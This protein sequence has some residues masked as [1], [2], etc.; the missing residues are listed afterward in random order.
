[1]ASVISNYALVSLSELLGALQQPGDTLGPQDNRRERIINQVSEEIESYLGRQLVTRGNLTEFHTLPS[2]RQEIRL[3]EFPATS[4]VSVHE[5]S[6]WEGKAYADWYGASTLL[7]A[8][9]HYLILT[10]AR[11]PGAGTRLYR[12]NSTWPMGRR[13]IKVVYTA[14]YANTAA[15]PAVIKGV[16]LEVCARIWRDQAQSQHGITSV[17]DATGTITRMLP[18]LLLEE[19]RRKL[20][21]YSN[22]EVAPTW[23]R[24]A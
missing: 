1:M 15:V 7:T 22:L 12:L 21:A 4:V 3:G 19:D 10:N 9:T 8:N 14:G 18:A 23:E 16:C 11:E 2:A 20:F 5:D 13:A 17:T 6:Y 24:A